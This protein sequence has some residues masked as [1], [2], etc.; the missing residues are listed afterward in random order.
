MHKVAGNNDYKIKRQTSKKSSAENRQQTYKTFYGACNHSFVLN[1]RSCC[2]S[3][4]RVQ[5]IVSTK[6][7]INKRK[8]ARYVLKMKLY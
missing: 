7:F 6:T 8:T 5:K 3:D 4:E 2:P 1:K